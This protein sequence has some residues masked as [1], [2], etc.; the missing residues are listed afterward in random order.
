MLSLQPGR[1]EAVTDD[2]NDVTICDAPGVGF[3]RIV[4]VVRYSNPDNVAHTPIVKT[5][6]GAAAAI[7][8]QRFPGVPSTATEDRWCS[9]V[10]PIILLPGDTLVGALGESATT[11]G[12][13]RVEYLTGTDTP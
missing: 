12:N 8:R 10:K 7:E 1:Q 2:T 6:V 9:A 13:W 3:T 5:K 11:E 4:Q